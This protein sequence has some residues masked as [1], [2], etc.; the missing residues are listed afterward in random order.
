M[1]FGVPTMFVALLESLATTPRDVSSLQVAI[2]GGSMVPPELI[3]R[4]KATFGCQFSTVYGQTESSPVLTQTR[5]D[6]PFEDLCETVGQALPQTE[7]SIRDPA[8]NQAVPVGVIGEICARGYCLMVEYNDNPAATAAAIDAQG[9]LHTGD[10]G[11]M[12]DRGFVKVT[13]RVKDMIIRGGE[14]LFPA[15]IENILLE[16]ADIAEVAV[17]GVPD[18][19][20]GEIVV[21]F[22]RLSAGAVMDVAT[23]RQH[24]RAN[25]SGPKTPARWV[26][27]DAWPLT[28]SGKIQKFVLRDRYVA[29]EWD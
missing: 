21:C 12:D 25:L 15:E 22:V 2:S 7:M 23:L 29:G 16:H 14:N 10:L 4:V 9:W 27:I 24:C 28:G 3:R 18:E 5:P 11:T 19:K 26:S 13:G 17:I 6:D 1:V 8:T 20:W